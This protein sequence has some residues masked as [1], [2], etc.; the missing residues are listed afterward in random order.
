[1]RRLE[2]GVTAIV[3][4]LAEH[5]RRAGLAEERSRAL[6]AELAAAWWEFNA[7]CWRAWWAYLYG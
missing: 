5:R 1:M 7:R 6:A 2:N 4:E 3:I